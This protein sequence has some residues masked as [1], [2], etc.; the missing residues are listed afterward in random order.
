MLQRGFT[1]GH[2]PGFCVDRVEPFCEL[3]QNRSL[4]GTVAGSQTDKNKIVSR[5]AHRRRTIFL[6][7]Q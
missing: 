2:F 5:H 1:Q 6:E 4:T 7:D 3:V